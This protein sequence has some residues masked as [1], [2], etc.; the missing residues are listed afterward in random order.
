MY[1]N[2]DIF[3]EDATGD[4][5]Q[6]YANRVFKCSA[7]G[8][9]ALRKINDG[10]MSRSVWV[11]ILFEHIYFYMAVTSEMG[12]YESDDERR[13]RVLSKLAKLL[14]SYASDYVFDDVRRDG[15]EGRKNQLLQQ[16]VIRVKEYSECKRIV[17][18]EGQD[19]LASTALGSLCSRVSDLA[20][21]P[22]EAAHVMTV[23]SHIQDSLDILGMDL[24]AAMAGSPSPSQ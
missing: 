7:I 20:G 13:E 18:L 9:N 3:G 10:E 8:A 11:T 4:I 15:N 23:H 21:Q 14:I 17:P 5:Y 24:F 12:L 16:C 19:R 6:K 2:I 1:Q 22:D